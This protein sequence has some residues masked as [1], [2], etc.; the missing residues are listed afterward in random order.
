MRVEIAVV[1][2]LSTGLELIW[3]RRLEKK[4]TDDIVMRSELEWAALLRRKSRNSQIREAGDI[5]INMTVHF[6]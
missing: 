6:F 4:N 3:N 1:A 5:M 2:L